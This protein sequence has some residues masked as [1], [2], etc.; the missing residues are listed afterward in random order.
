MLS[1]LLCAVI[2]YF[3][4]GQT[5]VT[6]KPHVPSAIIFTSEKNMILVVDDNPFDADAVKAWL[7]HEYI[8]TDTLYLKI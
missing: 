4:S 5:L 7:I 2:K 8:I 3:G 1:E 6:V